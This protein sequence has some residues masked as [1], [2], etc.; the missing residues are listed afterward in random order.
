[1]L[2]F[3]PTLLS[4][5]I[6]TDMSGIMLTEGW[7]FIGGGFSFTLFFWL[8]LLKYLWVTCF[9]KT[10]QKNYLRKKNQK[11]VHQAVIIYIQRDCGYFLTLYFAIVSKVAHLPDDSIVIVTSSWLFTDPRAWMGPTAT[12]SHGSVLYAYCNI[13]PLWWYCT[14]KII[15]LPC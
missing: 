6:L 13:I 11:K 10:K 5:K 9:H 3:L 4:I 8:Y 2:T 15:F 14:N 7:I 1:M 12:P